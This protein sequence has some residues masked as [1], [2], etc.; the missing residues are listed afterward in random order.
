MKSKC[1]IKRKLPPAP[2]T[3]TKT[4]RNDR[5]L[6]YGAYTYE[7]QVPVS[8]I[9]L[10][11]PPTKS[12]SKA[13]EAEREIKT[14]LDMARE[15]RT[16]TEISEATGYSRARVV[17]VVGRFA[18]YGAKLTPE[19]KKRRR[20]SAA[21]ASCHAWTEEATDQLIELHRQGLPYSDIGARLGVTKNSVTSKVQRLIEEGV[22][23][24]RVD[25]VVWSD[26]DMEKL[27]RLRAQGKTWAEIA[28]I[29]GRK[30][31]ACQMAYKREKGKR[32]EKARILRRMA[33]GGGNDRQHLQQ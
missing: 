5:M 3:A 12:D 23:Q 18:E 16:A 27:F 4:V 28:D 31:S 8:Q 24:P 32:N 13:A 29:F 26:E 9:E 25:Q 7:T 6:G 21:G 22:L 10:R 19:P 11:I 33:D 17:Q 15:G 1:S 2:P 30:L 14:I 20:K